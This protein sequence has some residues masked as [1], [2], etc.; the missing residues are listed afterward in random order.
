MRRVANVLQR[1]WRL[2]HTATPYARM[3]AASLADPA[4][5]WAAEAAAR[6]TWAS[7]W[8]T[9]RSCPASASSNALQTLSTDSLGRGQWF[10]GGKLNSC[11]NALDRHVEAGRAA[12][13]NGRLVVCF[14]HFTPLTTERDHLRQPSHAYHCALHIR[15]ASRA[16]S[17]VCRGTAAPWSRQRRPCRHLHAHGL[18]ARGMQSMQ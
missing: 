5:F 11:Y 1:A 10:A 16:D 8:H 2:A 9:V 6:V 17:G 14:P 3:H 13:V 4:G 12:K 7:P 15:H 18:L